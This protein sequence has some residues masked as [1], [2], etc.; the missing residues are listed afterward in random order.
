[1]MNV[2]DLPLGSLVDVLN[3]S[4]S[5]VSLFHLVAWHDEEHA[6]VV[7]HGV[8]GNL[9]EKA[10]EVVHVDRIVEAVNGNN[11]WRFKEV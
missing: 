1:M 11:V 9:D 3:E 10:H 2:T 6:V 7:R 4:G 5:G 8:G